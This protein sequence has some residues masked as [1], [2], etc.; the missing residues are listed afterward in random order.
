ML[1][2]YI[3]VWSKSLFCIY[4]IYLFVS[5]FAQERLNL[6]YFAIKIMY[7]SNIYF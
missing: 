5:D 6:N 1:N 2:V 3:D 4:I 7:W